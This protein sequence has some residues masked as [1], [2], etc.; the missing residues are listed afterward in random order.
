LSDALPV[1]LAVTP[2]GTLTLDPRHA[3][4]VIRGEVEI[5]LKQLAAR[6]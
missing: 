6:K 5:A 1:N 4:V 2:Y 3:E